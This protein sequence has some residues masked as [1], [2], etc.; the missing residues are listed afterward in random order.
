MHVAS[1][2][3]PPPLPMF[4]VNQEGYCNRYQ[5]RQ[6]LNPHVDEAFATIY[7]GSDNSDYSSDVNRVYRR[8]NIAL[9]KYHVSKIVNGEFHMQLSKASEATEL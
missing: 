4:R 7:P 2:C 1:L 9:D 6:H 8:M 5:N 3:R